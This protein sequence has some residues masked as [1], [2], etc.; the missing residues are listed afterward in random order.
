VFLLYSCGATVH[1]DYDNTTDFSSFK[2]YNYYDDIDSSLNELD[3]KRIMHATDSLLQLKGFIKSETP[4]FLIN[5]FAKEL[6]SD[7]RS[8]VGIGIGGGGGN[9]GV[10]VSGG[11]PIGGNMVIQTLTIDF[12][13]TS[14]DKLIWKA[15]GEGKIK[16]KANPS[17][18]EEF[19]TKMM[20]EILSEYPPKN[21]QL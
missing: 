3:D 2:S 11:I 6:L 12:V 16:E 20:I 19:Y 14:L 15:I 13:D 21:K 18:K 8:S 10:G 5:F 17:Q 7:S 9:V 1:Y 4:K